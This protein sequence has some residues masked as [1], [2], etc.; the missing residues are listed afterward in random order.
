MTSCFNDFLKVEPLSDISNEIYWKS[1]KDV[2]AELNAAY[3]HLQVAYKAG[4]LN[5]N[6]ARSDNFLGNVSGAN[7]YQNICFNKLNASLPAANWN[8]WYKM[9]SVANY[10]LH[11]VP[12]MKNVMSETKKNHLLSEAYF[13][14]AFAYFSLYRLWGDVP[15]ITEPVLKKSDVTKP[16]KAPKAKIMEL[17][18]ADLEEAVKL[19]D[20]NQTELFIYSPGALYALCTDVAMWNHKY[21]AAVDYSQKLFD[22]NKYSVENA[23]F[24]LVCSN[25]QTSDNIWTLKWDYA[26]NGENTIVMFY[27]NTASPL[28][29]TK[30]I[31]EKWQVW[32]NWSG[33]VDKRRE[34]TIDMT[35]LSAYGTNHVNVL[36]NSSRIWKWSPGERLDIPNFRES[37]IPLYRLAD[38][39]LLRAEALNK[40]NL[41]Q[42][43]INEMNKVRTRAGLK[44]KT[45]SDYPGTPSGVNSDGIE[46]DILQERQFELFAEGKRWFDLRRTEKVMSV[47]N[48]FYD[49]YIK[50]YGGVEYRK[51]TADWQFYW[52]VNQDVLNE[53]NN[54][55]QTGDY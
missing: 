37:Y 41:H 3:A 11:F 12:R 30:E 49:G 4:F 15:L 21:Q 13:I 47:M 5:W 23:N 42:D 46:E 20:N 55:S 38:I 48:L 53:N 25:A 40:L 27:Y 31:Y 45:L 43:A 33:T 14:R 28:I 16:D 8:Q 32:E 51:Y 7:P 19:V 17:I 54:L 44:K 22:L 52:P 39:V 36:P 1:E 9:V 50:T 35:R 29:P 26:A 6:E 10:A 2:R 24:S 34:A 18:N